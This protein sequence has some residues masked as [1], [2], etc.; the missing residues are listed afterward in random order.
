MRWFKPNLKSIYNILGQPDS[1]AESATK[2]TEEVRQAMLDT[3]TAAG[4]DV[5]YRETFSKIRYAGSIRSLWYARSD[6][7]LALADARGE[8]FAQRCMAEVSRLFMG[9]LPEA[10]DYRQHQR[11]R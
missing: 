7:M 10:R 1:M 9:A 11:L 3:M 5:Q 8:A 6:V 2:R 4:L